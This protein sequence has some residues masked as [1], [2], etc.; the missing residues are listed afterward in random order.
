MIEHELDAA[1]G[2]EAAREG[3][4][5]AALIRRHVGERLLPLPRLEAIH[6]SEIVG[7]VEGEPGDSTAVDAVV[8]ER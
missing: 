6:C 7:V 1:L 5:K 4:S 3:T 8:Y 2:R